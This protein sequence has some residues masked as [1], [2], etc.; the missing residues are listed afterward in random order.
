MP[1]T[2]TCIPGSVNEQ[3]SDI[4]HDALNSSSDVEEIDTSVEAPSDMN[5]SPIQR[6]V[7]I[8]YIKLLRSTEACTS[9]S[10]WHLL[11]WS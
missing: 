2:F 4:G 9:D 7:S 10:C 8:C 6:Y 5:V 3:R 11:R 1:H